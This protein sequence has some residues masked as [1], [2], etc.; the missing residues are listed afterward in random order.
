MGRR[1]ARQGSLDGSL[2]ACVVADAAGQKTVLWR[3]LDGQEIANTLAMPDG[4][5]L[6]GSCG[7]NT[8][9][10]GDTRSPSQSMQSPR[11]RGES[12]AGRAPSRQRLGSERGFEQMIV[13]E[14]SARR[15]LRQVPTG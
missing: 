14:S 7:R 13:D 10:M 6:D 12:F 2:R 9:A 5:G 4:I 15:G 8:N 3:T 11:V 1:Q